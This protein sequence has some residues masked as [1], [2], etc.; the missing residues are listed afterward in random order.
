[1][2]EAAHPE[3][4]LL[5]ALCVASGLGAAAA[6]QARPQ[7]ALEHVVK[8]PGEGG[9]D[10]LAVDAE[11]GHLFIAHGTRVDVIDTERL[12]RTG[13]IADTPGV[14]G[15][16]LAPGLGR[17]FISAGAAN[18]VVE[19]DLK[20][21]A[22]LREAHT[23]GDGPDAIVFEPTTQRVL[24]FNGRG[25][26]ASVFD[27]RSL[28]LVGTVAL[29]AKPEAAVA[30]GRGQVFVNLEDRNSVAVLDVRS[31]TVRTVWPLGGC[32]GPS[33]IA[34]NEAARQ[35][36]SVC[37]NEV[38]AVMDAADGH[39]LGTAPIGGG[40]DDAA[41]D[42]DARLAFASCGAGVVT[43]IAQ[44]PD[45]RPQ[46]AQVIATQRGARTMALDAKHHRLYLVTASF[47]A[48]PPAT[49][50]HPHPRPAIEPGSFRLLVLSRMREKM[51]T[52]AA[53]PAP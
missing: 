42:A 23:S 40:V 29:D 33:G 8:L 5:L 10:Y 36:Y 41:Y 46:V 37:S 20:T 7:Y 14:H 11:A 50:E 53:G 34:Y 9:W 49:A 44:A 21:L 15:I 32:E 47:G 19:F 48:A 27:A 4:T 52:S 13:E 17:G 24:T 26:N 18:S 35:L 16:A 1:V 31:L 43:A 6:V 38:M 3:R 51:T 45:G 12:Q 25:H 22:R 28:E 39:L 2:Q 30:D